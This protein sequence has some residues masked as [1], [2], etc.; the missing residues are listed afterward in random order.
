MEKKNKQVAARGDG[1]T[2]GKKQVREIT[3]HKYPVPK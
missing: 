2:G 3:R 1:G